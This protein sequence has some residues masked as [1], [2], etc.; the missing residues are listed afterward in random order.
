MNFVSPQ[1]VQQTP[2]LQ[3]QGGFPLGRVVSPFQSP[4]LQQNPIP[5]AGGFVSQPYQIHPQIQSGVSSPMMRSNLSVFQQG[6][7]PQQNRTSNSQADLGQYLRS[8]QSTQKQENQLQRYQNTEPIKKQIASNQHFISPQYI[9]QQTNTGQYIQSNQTQKIQRQTSFHQQQL[10]N[11][12]LTMQSLPAN[13]NTINITS[14]TSPNE[15]LLSR[16]LSPQPSHRLN[17]LLSSPIQRAISP[18][19]QRINKDS[20][21]GT[22][23]TANQN[24]LVTQQGP[25]MLGVAQTLYTPS[26]RAQSPTFNQNQGFMFTGR[27]N[28]VQ[29]P[30]QTFYSS[31]QNFYKTNSM[32]QQQQQQF[33]PFKLELPQKVQDNQQKLN[34]AIAK[35]EKVKKLVA[36]KQ[37]QM[38]ANE[39]K[40]QELL[41][42]SKLYDLTPQQTAEKVK[43]KQQ[44]PIK[45][46]ESPIKTI[47]QVINTNKQGPQKHIINSIV[48]SDN[49]NMIP[50]G[51]IANQNNSISNPQTSYAQRQAENLHI[52]ISQNGN[53]E[54]S[55]QTLNQIS[56]NQAE[57]KKLQL[58]FKNSVNKIKETPKQ[59]LIQTPISLL[60]KSNLKLDQSQ[61]NENKEN[62]IISTPITN[63]QN[64]DQ[65]P[66]GDQKIEFKSTVNQFRKSFQKNMYQTPQNSKKKF[67]KKVYENEDE[68]QGSME[69]D[70]PNGYGILR[71]KNGKELYKG[72]W[73]NGQYDGSGILVNRNQNDSQAIVIDHNEL[74][75]ILTLNLWIRY[76][77]D[78][79]QNQIQGFGTMY[80]IDNLKYVGNFAQGI[81]EGQG[82]FYTNDGKVIAGVWEQGKLKDI[83]WD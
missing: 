17:S 53:T 6:Q 31:G 18:Q 50:I 36:E 71:D 45:Q 8:P 69:N 78:M 10:Q 27:N 81:P 49:K 75:Q 7:I 82:S 61:P 33:I 47:Q 9:Q 15:R 72:D 57:F 83:L 14:A 63:N 16:N 48:N 24:Q 30:Q 20:F 38:K 70:I 79:K 74:S 4:Y 54:E 65:T 60:Q 42:V 59:Q 80:F 23:Q 21:N 41:D 22:V 13:N 73:K 46:E 29:S 37:Q 35:S 52:S 40:R 2:K 55:E 68:Y 25:Y 19:T 39:Q 28:F 67:Q 58:E 77:G 12:R 43:N 11:S 76:E 51:T 66:T 44:T 3:I 1:I 64:G 56:Q 32:P 5:Q 62:C 26:S 34:E